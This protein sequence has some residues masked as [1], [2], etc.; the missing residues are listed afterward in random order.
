MAVLQEIAEQV[1][2]QIQP[3]GSDESATSLEEII[4]SARTIYSTLIWTAARNER[5]TEGFYDVPSYLLTEVEKE[6]VNNEMDISDIKALK[7]LPNESW[8]LNVGGLAC[9]CDYIK[10]TVNRTALLCD[11][12]TFDELKTY[13]IVGNKIKFPKGVHKPSLPILYAN[14]G[15]TTDPLI[16]IDESIAGLLRDKLQDAYNI[17][18]IGREDVTNNSSSVS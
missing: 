1:W 11:D 7:S 8:L 13:Y 14:N 6:V 3:R 5:N 16:Y 12:E 2:L 18:K 9:E 17:Q 10:S 15:S 4:S